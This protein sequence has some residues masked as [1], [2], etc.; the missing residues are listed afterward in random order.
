MK[1]FLKRLF[2]RGRL[3]P[4]AKVSNSQPTPVPQGLA[5][6]PDVPWQ[7][8]GS[9]K[10]LASAAFS[11]NAGDMCGQLWLLSTDR[12]LMDSH[13]TDTPL[14]NVFS[15]QGFKAPL[16]VITAGCFGDGFFRV[17]KSS[18]QEL[19]A[20]IQRADVSRLYS[21]NQEYVPFYCP[22]CQANYGSSEWMTGPV[23]DDGFFDYLEGACPKG[24]RRM[25]HD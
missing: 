1:G 3:A 19:L 8:G 5:R 10:C 18:L 12:E 14:P 2:E 23:Y 16:G 17:E 20:P 11:T 9:V 6:G 24:H 4:L 13:G 15:A 21:L 7:H 22:R 25:I